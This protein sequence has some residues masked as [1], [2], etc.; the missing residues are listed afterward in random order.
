MS[1]YDDLGQRP[2]GGKAFIVM[3]GLVVV[4]LIGLFMLFGT[5]GTVKTGEVGVLTT[6]GKVSGTKEPGFYMK[7]PFFQKMTKID[8]RNQTV[9]YDKNGAEGDDIDTSSLSASSRDIQQVW[10]NIVVNWK[11]D[12][13]KSVEIF[14]QY[15]NTENFSE[16]VIEPIIRESVKSFTAQY[17]AEELTTKRQE[18]SDKVYND[19]LVKL[20]EKGVILAQSNLTNFEYSAKFNEAIENKVKAEQ[21]AKAAQNKLEQVKFEQEAKVVEAKATAEA[22]RIQAQAITQQGGKDYVQLKALEKWN[23]QLP[24]QMI[25][26]ST[27]PF[28]NLNQ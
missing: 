22:I 9:N 28:I 11:I 1:S 12:P 14:S 21:D 10:A 20:P 15:R 5:F 26:G 13:A 24:Q 4:V 6:L 8:L 3:V 17:T 19:L 25:P 7:V 23:G 16:N 27:V 2:S 18:I